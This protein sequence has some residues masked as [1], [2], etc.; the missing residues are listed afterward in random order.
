MSLLYEGILGTEDCRLI[1]PADSRHEAVVRS[2]AHRRL[3]VGHTYFILD[4][5]TLLIIIPRKTASAL[6]DLQLTL[7]GVR[8]AHLKGRTFSSSGL[9]LEDLNQRRRNGRVMRLIRRAVPRQPNKKE[10]YDLGQD[11]LFVMHPYWRTLGEDPGPA[12]YVPYYDDR[13]ERSQ[14][15]PMTAHDFSELIGY[16]SG[17]VVRLQGYP[18]EVNGFFHKGQSLKVGH[19]NE[20]RCFQ[21]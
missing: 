18:L 6:D 11:F 8:T 2:K 14:L 21:I 19:L 4:E 1:L 16:A 10:R 3:C 20:G 12:G 9:Y 15:E 5:G 13:H 17:C 7:Q